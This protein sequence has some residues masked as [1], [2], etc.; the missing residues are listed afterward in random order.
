MGNEDTN[1]L[2]NA[3][4]LRL[5]GVSRRFPVSFGLRSRT[6]LADVD[7]EVPR[8][9]TLGLIGPNGSG[10]STLLR[11]AAGVDRPSGGR[12][13]LFGRDLAR[14]ESRAARA[15][16]GYLPDDSP[17]PADL[18]GRSALE[19]IASLAGLSRRERARRVPNM[20][21]KVGLEEAGGRAL[22]GYSGGMLRRFG[23]AQAFL[24]DPQ[25]VLLDEPTAGLD[26]LGHR[27]LDELIAEARGR[28]AAVV[29]A[30]HVVSDLHAASD[31]I[32]VMIGGALAALGPPA[33]VLSSDETIDLR[34][35][36]LDARGREALSAW[37]H[38]NG[39]T[40]SNAESGQ[41][42]LSALFERLT[43]QGKNS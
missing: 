39:A 24:D 3:P 19:L 38:E 1:D 25:L 2:P 43:G 9:G 42:A 4:A 36:G 20:L 26:V 30:S 35:H 21:E 6:A 34:V 37:A 29:V 33:E 10:K 17:F 31:R 8:G 15:L 13:E 14:R 11:I 18:S 40:I 5:A 41:L 27:V 22:R 28:G 12:A 32:A 16:L 23:L 7:L